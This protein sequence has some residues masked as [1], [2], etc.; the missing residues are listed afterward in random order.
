MIKLKLS[1]LWKTLFSEWKDR[2][3]WKTV[4]QIIYLTKDFYAGYLKNAQNLTI[5]K[6]I[7]KS[8]KD[9]KRHFTKAN[10]QFPNKH[11]KRCST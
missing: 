8:A 4:L 11:M 9:L 3:D 7:K 10:M 1:T 5:K 6:Y 2:L